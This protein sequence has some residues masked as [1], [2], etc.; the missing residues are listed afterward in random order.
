MRTNNLISRSPISALLLAL[1]LT[2]CGEKPE[3]MLNSAKD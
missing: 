2:A 1:L 3:T